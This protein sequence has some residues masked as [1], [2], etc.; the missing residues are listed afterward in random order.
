MRGWKRGKLVFEERYEVTPDSLD[1]IPEAAAERHAELLTDNGRDAPHMVEF[2]WLD[3]PNPL[4]RFTRIGTD[5][6]AMVE[7]VVVDS[8]R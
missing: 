8:P 5:P 7:P 4:Q 6:S 2:E 3:E 1:S